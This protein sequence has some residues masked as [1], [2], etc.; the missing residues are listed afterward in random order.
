MVDSE[1]VLLWSKIISG[2]YTGLNYSFANNEIYAGAAIPTLGT[3][4]MTA[5]ILKI[6]EN[7][8]LA[9]GR[10]FK[11]A[12]QTSAFDPIFGVDAVRS[13]GVNAE[14]LCFSSYRSIFKMDTTI[15]NSNC[16]TRDTSFI[17]TSIV[18]EMLP[19]NPLVSDFNNLQGPFPALIMISEMDFQK[20]DAC[21]FSSGLNS[22]H[23]KLVKVTVFPNPSYDLLTFVTEEFSTV[24]TYSITDQTGRKHLQGT[25]VGNSVTTDIHELATGVYFLHIIGKEM[26]VVKFLKQ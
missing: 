22:A 10:M 18:P 2:T 5:T 7:G 12:E 25:F 15:T 19:I 11:Q 9:W 4:F 26:H 17:A 14:R 8:D 6:H 20:Y 13:L 16:Y 23:S 21:D 24:G 1:G 3:N